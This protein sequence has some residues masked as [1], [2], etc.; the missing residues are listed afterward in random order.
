MQ[1]RSDVPKATSVKSI[2]GEYLLIRN[3][4]FMNP[5]LAG[6]MS[7]TYTASQSVDHA[8]E[9]KPPNEPRPEESRLSQESA[10]DRVRKE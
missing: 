8:I 7:S 2:N 10:I 3:T 5:R 4:V 1:M 9:E 6:Q